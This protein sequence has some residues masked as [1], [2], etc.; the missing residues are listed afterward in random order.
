VS[1]V[2]RVKLLFSEGV[3]LETVSNTYRPVLDGSTRRVTKVGA[4][5]FDYVMLDGEQAGENGHSYFPKRA[6]DV[7]SVSDDEVTY[8]LSRDG[9]TVTLR[10]VG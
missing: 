3:V 7:V 5:Y 1:T 4:S 8:K 6:S 2:E 10:V 9:H